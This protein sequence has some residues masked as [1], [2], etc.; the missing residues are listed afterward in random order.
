MIKRFLIYLEP[1][2]WGLIKS[3]TLFIVVQGKRRVSCCYTSTLCRLCFFL[4][5]SRIAILNTARAPRHTR[6][7]GEDVS[8]KD[9]KSDIFIKVMISKCFFYCHR[10]RR[11][12]HIKMAG[13]KTNILRKLHLHKRNVV[14][15]FIFIFFSSSRVQGC[16]VC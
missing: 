2:V 6:E 10:H 8:T 3:V 16:A 14:G 11:D 12:P 9:G 7:P 1:L 15:W 4:C 5:K 13:K